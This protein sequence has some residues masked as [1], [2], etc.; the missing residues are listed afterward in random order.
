MS[1]STNASTAISDH[2]KYM[3]GVAT[4]R[5]YRA[6]YNSD[7]NPNRELRLWASNPAIHSW[8]RDTSP[9]PSPF[10]R[11]AT[12]RFVKADRSVYL[13]PQPIAPVTMVAR[14]NGTDIGRAVVPPNQGSHISFHESGVVNVH[15]IGPRSLRIR[16]AQAVDNATPLFTCGFGNM[17]GYGPESKA[18]ADGVVVEASRP[19]D[20]PTFVSIFALSRGVELD[21][22]KPHAIL[23]HA[24]IE[25]VLSVAPSGARYLFAG[26]TSPP[27]TFRNACGG[28]SADFVVLPGLPQGVSIRRPD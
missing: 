20:W 12:V 3:A 17:D 25:T 22:G 5:W 4:G 13:V 21:D 27:E 2:D 24:P 9:E 11:V 28:K 16:R 15:G 10:L 19:A 1:S 23:S 14:R 18:N 8:H 7:Q 6:T 26:W